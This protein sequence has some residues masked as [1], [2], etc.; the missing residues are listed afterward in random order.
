MYL[1]VMP[2]DFTNQ[3]KVS[4]LTKLKNYTKIFQLFEWTTLLQKSHQI[5]NKTNFHIDG[6]GIKFGLETLN[7]SAISATE[8]N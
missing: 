3:R 8:R 7:I 4:K 5:D 6:N 1:L 2:K